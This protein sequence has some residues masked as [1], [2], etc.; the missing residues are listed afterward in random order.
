MSLIPLTLVG[1]SVSAA[2]KEPVS[3]RIQRD[4]HVK[5]GDELSRFVSSEHAG[6]AYYLAAFKS[7]LNVK[8]VA[9]RMPLSVALP[10]NRHFKGPGMYMAHSGGG[11][12]VG[13]LVLLDE[14]EAGRFSIKT[15]QFDETQLIKEAE[16]QGVATYSISEDLDQGDFWQGADDLARQAVRATFRRAILGCTLITLTLGGL[17]AGG[18]VFSALQ[19]PVIAQRREDAR[20]AIDKAVA[21]V[22]E[23]GANAAPK[24]LE[25]LD[26]LVAIVDKE[27]GVLQQF[28][29]E[30]GVT[31]FVFQVPMSANYE[32]W[33]GIGP[34][35]SKVSEDGQS[36]TV[37]SPNASKSTTASARK[38]F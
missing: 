6:Q 14:R 9:L 8:G 15:F 18:A 13:V 32:S 37:Q 24:A 16:A 19:E 26:R 34:V 12:W 25:D 20:A 29:S 31:E 10:G 11:Q 2:G 35:Q 30:A 23:S 28:K 7:D 21:L 36:R 5:L 38:V 33:K 1:G 4:A 22:S 27:L 17:T 3:I